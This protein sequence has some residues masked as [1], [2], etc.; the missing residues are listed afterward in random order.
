VSQ[1]ALDYS[2]WRFRLT[3]FSRRMRIW[4]ARSQLRL[5]KRLMM[6]SKAF[7]PIDDAFDQAIFIRL[8]TESMAIVGYAVPKVPCHLRH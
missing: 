6:E 8:W 7:F 4:A 5:V 3:S 1:W 2:L